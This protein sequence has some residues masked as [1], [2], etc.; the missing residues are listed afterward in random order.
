M[1]RT[2]A[3]GIDLGTTYSAVAWVEDS[4]KTVMIP[5]SE[6]DVLTPSLV[7]FEDNEVLVGKEAKK[8]GV[9]KPNRFA[10]CV[11]RD[12]GAP[13]YSRPISGEYMPPEV[14]QAWILKKLKADI[15]KA[16][17]P[18]MRVVIT[19]PAFF[20][21]QRRKATA[22]AGAMAA[23]PVLDVV[24]EP[25]AAALAFGEEL[26]YLSPTGTVREPLTV[27]V[28]DLGGGTF[29]V[30]LL[31]MRPGD[32]RTLA[33][34]GDVQLGGRDWD[35][36][37][38]DMA[39]E[40]FIQEHREDPRQNPASLQ[41][42]LTEVEDA[43]RTLSARQNA[44]IRV[45][46]TGNSTSVKVS[47]EQFEQITADLLERTAYTTRQLLATAGLTWEQVDRVLLVGGSTRMPMVGRMLEQ[48]S[49]IKPDQ[50]VHPDEAVARGAAI[51]AG[52]LLATQPD[53]LKPPAF[54][55]TDV[56]SHSLG[57]EGI[58]SRTMRKR[59]VIVIPRNTP[60]P[61]KVKERFV[62]KAAGQ[63][64]IVV[65]VLEGESAIPSECTEIGRT[66]VKDLPPGL[67]VGWPIEIDY[68][69]GTNG[70][71]KVK[72]QVPGTHRE[73]QLELERES[74]M[75]DERMARWKQV[76]S[77]DAGFDA[78]TSLIADELKANQER[79]EAYSP[80][81]FAEHVIEQAAAAAALNAA[82]PNAAVPNAAVPNA[83]VPN[84]TVPSTTAPASNSPT[85]RGQAIAPGRS[86]ASSAGSIP[87]WS[88]TPVLLT[89]KPV[90]GAVP[91]PVAVQPSVAQAAPIAMPT[92]APIQARPAAPA[93]AA[94][95]PAPIPLAP[96]SKP[97]LQGDSQQA[98]T[99]D[100]EKQAKKR[101]RRRSKQIAAI[102]NVSGFL[103]ASLLGLTIGYYVLCYVNPSGNFLQ[104]PPSCFPWNMEQP[105]A[106]GGNAP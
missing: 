23:L 73:V 11:K 30:T 41:R 12:M 2:R 92:A 59:N 6:G 49:G 36:R 64:S 70:R 83:T 87:A 4:G 58:D 8:L 82:A 76:I 29:D 27:L 61:A 84:A 18:D 91:A 39:A 94:A 9:M 96:P 47:R 20:D 85:V 66:V 46:H 35:M 95:S 48:L 42:L 52:Y 75:S 16:V 13:V 19:V 54:Q 22:D 68:E 81:A 103:F 28:Y 106:G 104:L 98:A 56:N 40:V 37:L 60:L 102:V 77:G 69:Y 7:L 72:A 50:R 57:I 3:V 43:K 15:Y 80:V 97:L 45:D 21:E 93:A 101:R 65:Q 51:F 17:G 67:P 62:T 71:L 25:T 32:L 88:T 78:F 55:V 10:E 1:S 105:P 44:T 38:A 14:I 53:S 31:A 63:R 86:G 89:P 99:A 100:H 24:N 33:T 79:R 74:A 5:N 34:D 26:G 90:A